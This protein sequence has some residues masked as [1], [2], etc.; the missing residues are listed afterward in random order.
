[1]PLQ[2]SLSIERMCQLTPVSRAG[3]YRWLQE[4]PP[5]KRRRGDASYVARIAPWKWKPG[6]CPNPGGRPK[7]DIAK[8]IAQAVFANNAEALY[9]TYTKAALKGNAYAFKELVSTPAQNGA[10]FADSGRSQG[11]SWE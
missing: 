8:E 6:H 9:K 10:V 5:Q 4:P 7:N 3:F 1:M 11:A 2:G